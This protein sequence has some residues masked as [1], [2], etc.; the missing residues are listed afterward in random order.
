MYT[1]DQFLPISGL[2][3]L[4]FCPRQC[5]LIHLEQC[6]SENYLTA[7][8]RVMHERV[9]EGP[10]ESRGDVRTVRGL[11]LCSHRL[12]LSGIA[13]AVEFHRTDSERGVRIPKV[14]GFWSPYPVEY[15]HGRP[16]KGNCDAVQLCAQAVCLEEMLGVAI[17]EGA[18]FYGQTRRRQ[19]VPFD[20]SL[21]NETADFAL[22]F[23]QLI[24][25]GV[26]PPASSVP[27]CSSCSLAE[28][29]M[30]N[31][32]HSARAYIN[33]NLKE[34]LNSAALDE[35]TSGNT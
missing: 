25:N 23:H 7:S 28:I 17:S 5:A 33:R 13:D 34:N 26:T 2:Q 24:E 35:D 30:P 6:W 32:L 10:N 16:K 29:C 11:A 15:K 19:V 14:S 1:E 31:S 22:Q 20:D 21:R 3:H 12:G 18:L 8:G 27:F 9:H 4:S